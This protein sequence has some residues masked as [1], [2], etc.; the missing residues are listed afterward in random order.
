MNSIMYQSGI[1][2]LN[3]KRLTI[4]KRILYNMYNSHAK[5]KGFVRVYSNKFRFV[6]PN[7]YVD[8]AISF[9]WQV[10]IVFRYGFK[11]SCHNI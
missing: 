9:E 2:I 4:R 7:N 11:I 3:N 5:Q 6:F 1:H 8:G 10:D